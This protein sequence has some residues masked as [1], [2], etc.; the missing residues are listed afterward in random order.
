MTDKW[1]LIVGTLSFG[2]G[3]LVGFR[4]KAQ[5]KTKFVDRYLST[6]KDGNSRSLAFPWVAIG[7]QVYILLM[8]FG[9]GVAGGYQ[10]H[11]LLDEIDEYWGSK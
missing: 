8:F 3:V 11:S 6:K 10:L 2:I 9:V 1:L 4:F 5:I 7:T